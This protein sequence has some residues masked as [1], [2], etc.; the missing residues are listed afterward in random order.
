MADAI[1]E[2]FSGE[3]FAVLT[4]NNDRNVKN[5]KKAVDKVKTALPILLDRESATV[6]AYRAFAPPT[7]YLLDRNH[8]IA[9]VWT[10]SVKD[11]TDQLNKSIRTALETV[12]GEAS[13]A[14]S[15]GAESAEQ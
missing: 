5:V 15:A 3:E 8:K 7:L 14:I 4:I 10:G 1:S 13:P 6:D 11:K 9:A 2:K 12:E